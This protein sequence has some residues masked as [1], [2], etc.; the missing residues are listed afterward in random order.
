MQRTMARVL[1]WG[2]WL[3]GGLW[4]WSCALDPSGT[5]LFPA[6]GTGTGAGTG[7]ATGTGTAAATG[8]GTGTTTG[9]ATG[10]GTGTATGTGSAVGGQGG[11]GGA[12]G[13]TGGGGSG[14]EGGA[15]GSV[16]DPTE[17]SGL[18]LWLRADAGVSHTANSVSAWAD[19]SGQANDAIAPTILSQPVLDSVAMNGHPAIVFDGVDDVLA[20]A[21]APGLDPG[22]G[23]YLCVAVGTWL[24]G[25][26]GY[27]VW[28]GK[29]SGIDGSS[30]RMFRA[31]TQVLQLLWGIDSEAYP[32]HSVVVTEGVDYVMG[33]GLD[34]N[35]SEVI[36]V[37][38]STISRIG[39]TV[40]G[41]GDSVLP[42]TMAA[43]SS[44]NY[45]ARIR[46]AEQVFYRRGG[47]GFS[48]AELSALINYFRGR[49][50]L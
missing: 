4:L 21:D 38:D 10:T 22:N 40:S 6:S 14:G 2:V 45:V 12:G 46:V 33:W 13:S 20:I 34:A 39:V 41:T 31:D 17:L 28:F 18:R 5:A 15:G 48:D 26:S 11:Q 9:T 1:K 47:A 19:Q 42:A 16:T 50:G 25:N 23:R 8:T 7:T 49:Y 37:V 27:K 3:A 32:R 29:S 36:Y 35:T 24:A 43:D 44:P 30:W